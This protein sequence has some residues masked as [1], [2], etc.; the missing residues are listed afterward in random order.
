MKHRNAFLG[1]FSLLLAEDTEIMLTE[2]DASLDNG[3][4]YFSVE[5]IQELIRE[6]FS[7]PLGTRWLCISRRRWVWVLRPSSI[8]G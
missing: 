5:W 6:M 4:K 8:P 2:D 1:V 7:G 3:R